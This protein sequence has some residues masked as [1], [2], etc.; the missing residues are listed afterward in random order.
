MK[1]DEMLCLLINTVF[2][3]ES[4]GGAILSSTRKGLYFFADDFF[5]KDLPLLSG[6]YAGI[7]ILANFNSVIQYF[8]FGAAGTFP[9]KF[10]DFHLFFSSVNLN[11]YCEPH[12][13]TVYLY[14]E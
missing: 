9:A 1:I 3:Q 7:G 13:L 11:F 14:L 10:Y 8:H 6:E 4:A 2:H 5:F 12:P